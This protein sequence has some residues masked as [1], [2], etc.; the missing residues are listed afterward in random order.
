MKPIHMR[1]Y[2]TPEGVIRAIYRLWNDKRRWLQGPVAVTAE[3][4][5][6]DPEDPTA[7]RVCLLGGLER[8]TL[9]REVASCALDLLW[10]VACEGELSP[11]AI[12]EEQGYAAIRKLMRKALKGKV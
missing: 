7:C 1:K 10:G 8:F 2:K 11:V 5:D 3:G 6:T 9:T 4:R 12:N